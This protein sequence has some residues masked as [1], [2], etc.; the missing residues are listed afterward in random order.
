VE[1]VD[2]RAGIDGLAAL[3]RQQSHLL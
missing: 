1:P 2:F 3:C